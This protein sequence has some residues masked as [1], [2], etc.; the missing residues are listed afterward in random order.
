MDAATALK[1]EG[2]KALQENHF[3]KATEL[4]SQAIELHPTAILYSNR[5]LAAIRMEN[6]GMAI[7]DAEAA[8]DLDPSYLK[9]FYRR[10]SANYALGKNKEA[11]RD[12]KHV[13]KVHPRDKDAAAKFRECEKAVKAA[14]FAAAIQTEDSMPLSQTVQPD[15][16]IVEDSYDG[17]T[18]DVPPP[19]EEEVGREGGVAMG[20]GKVI[21]VCGD[22][23]GQFF[24][25]LR[26]FE[27]NGKP[28]NSN[29]YLFNGDFVDRGS[30]SFEVIT[31]LLAYK[32]AY[33]M[34]M[35]LVRGNHESKNMNRIYG[36][37]GE[38]KHKY[39]EVMMGLFTEVFCAMPLCATIDSSIFIVHGGL[40]AEDGVTLDDINKVYRFREPPESGLMS[41]LLW[42]DP[43]PAPGRQPSKRGVGLSFGPDVTARFLDLN[44]LKM[45]V[46]SHEVKEEGYSV[47]HDGKCVTVFSAPNYCDQ[48]GN[49]GAFIRFCHGENEPVYTQFEAAPHPPI[50][51]MAY[52][53]NMMGL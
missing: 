40:A 36:F 48:M 41:D 23:H 24:D 31:L 13:F 35:H 39:D 19:S 43:Q 6:Y 51:P 29:P 4:Y 38:V 10:G 7:Q 47:E 25:V 5:A 44:K 30:F 26:I 45:V 52:A 32:V 37:E 46:R 11:L 49:K 22:T 2:N 50:K 20:K 1:D 21:T 3:E 42:S 9:A 17:P 28:S 16:I 18:A 8:I 34:G 53:R 33:P 14:A 27:L 12:F 15:S